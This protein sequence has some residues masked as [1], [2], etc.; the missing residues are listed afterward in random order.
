[1]VV[2]AMPQDMLQI[3]QIVGLNE[4]QEPTTAAFLQLKE[5]T[6]CAGTWLE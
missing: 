6:R 2:E 5:K 1:M 4:F 3:L